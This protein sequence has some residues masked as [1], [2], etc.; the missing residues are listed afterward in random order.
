MAVIGV[1]GMGQGHCSSIMSLVKAGKE[2]VQIVAVA[3]VCKRNVENAL[4]A[5]SEGQGIEVKGYRHYRD[6]LN[7]A[8]IQAVLIASPEHW[9]AQMA[10]DAIRAGKDAYVEKPMTL[11]LDD[12][13]RL[14]RDEHKSDRIVQVGTQYVTE[15]KYH[16]A[17]RLIREGVI[18]KPVSSQTSY[19]RNSKIGEWNY[20]EVF[21]DNVPG[22][23][24]DWDG[25]LGHM[26]PMSFDT[27]V[28]HR[29][30][31]YRKFSTGIIGDLLVHVTTPMMMALDV[32]WPVR[33]TAVGGHYI[34]KE[35]ENHD[36]LNITVQFEKEHTMIISGST[37]NEL[38]LEPVI[39]GNKG[40]IFLSSNRCLMRPEREYQEGIEEHDF[41]YEYEDPQDRHR[42]NFF[43]CVRTREKPL[44]PVEMGVK[45]MVIVDLATRSLWEGASFGFS[46]ASM[47]AYR[48]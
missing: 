15:P 20:Y 4:K 35:M 10:I 3:D 27:L 26:G 46:P 28:F 2:N 37:C 41:R 34:D 1:G 5:C 45:M 43:K 33:V 22:E 32:G 24:L 36:Q 48:I 7:D 21:P 47:S 40:N 25:W 11:T 8:S 12:A 14:W 29:W 39:H 18:G 19:C 13:Q 38:G 30:R 17:A 31:R 23:G 42:L 44:S 16:E 6:L 9:H